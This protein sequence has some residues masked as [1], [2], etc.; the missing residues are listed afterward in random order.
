MASAKFNFGEKSQSV[1][2]SLAQAANDADDIVSVY[3]DRGYDSGGS[4]QIVDGDIIEGLNITAAQLGLLITL[5]QQLAKFVGNAAVTQ[6]DYDAT[7]N[8]IR[9]DL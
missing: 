9:S 5:F 7:L 8:V 4:D 3:F 2:T 6:A 1:A